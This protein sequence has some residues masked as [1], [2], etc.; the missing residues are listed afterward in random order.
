MG[1]MVI[2][3]A[4]LVIALRA[5][6]D[7]LADLVGGFAPQDLVRTSG[8]DEWSVAQV[9][10]HLG[11]GAVINLTTLD[12]ALGIA[13]PPAPDFPRQVW[14]RWD[15]MEA[16]EQAA[17]LLAADRALVERYESIPAAESA[18]IRVHFPWMPSP[19]PLADAARMRLNE[20]ALHSWDVRVAFDP[21][22]V[23]SEVSVPLLMTGIPGLV[24]RVA[25]PE[26]LADRPATV[27][28]TTVAPDSH[29]TLAIGESAAI[30]FDHPASGENRLTLPAECWLR[31]VTGRLRAEHTPVGVHSTGPVGLEQLRAVFPGY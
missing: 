3:V 4:D 7:G 16:R 8:A 23:V 1:F 28:V 14:A 24:G 29:L 10:S 22:A 15:A 31:L 13:P 19:M 18:R 26:A 12:A 9:L 5:E 11:S 30:Y 20:V 17:E 25:R 27:A 2:R 21:G 6:H